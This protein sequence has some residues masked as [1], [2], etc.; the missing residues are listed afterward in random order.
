[1]K[2]ANNVIILDE[3][4]TNNVF[5]LTC[6]KFGADE[7]VEKL[8]EIRQMARYFDEVE[9]KNERKNVVHPLLKEL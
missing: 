1:M 7:N 9:G 5:V 3:Y 6:R 2:R 4:D 8:C